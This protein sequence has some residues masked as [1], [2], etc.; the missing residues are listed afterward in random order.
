M[1]NSR[2]KKIV[3]L[4]LLSAIAYLLILLDFPLLPSFSF[5]KLDFSDIIVFISSF[6]YGPSGGATVAFIRSLLHFITTGASL[7]NLVGDATSFLASLLFMAPVYLF[8]KRY[9][10]QKKHLWGLVLGTIS[11]T[12]FMSLAN[13]F[14][15]TPVYV[16]LMGFSYGIPMSQV[17]LTGILPFNLI[18]GSAISVIFVLVHKQILPWLSRKLI[19]EGK[20]TKHKTL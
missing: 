4:A 17:I 20:T 9:P 1:R 19:A 14:V 11:L 8:Y 15:I 6:I 7:P 5:L 2:T 13:Y 3:V 16:K 10:T 18:K 12:I